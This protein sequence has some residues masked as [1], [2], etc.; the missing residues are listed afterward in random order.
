MAIS[1]FLA[2]CNPLRISNLNFCFILFFAENKGSHVMA[3]LQQLRS[4]GLERHFA[5]HKTSN[6]ATSHLQ[7][8][9]QFLDMMG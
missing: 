5:V 7:G 3:C 6:N 1:D 9:I 2:Y 4:C 8:V